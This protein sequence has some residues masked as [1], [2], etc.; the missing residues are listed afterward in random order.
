MRVGFR[1]WVV[2][3][4]FSGMNPLQAGTDVNV[5]EPLRPWV[6][7]VLHAEQQ[8]G[9]PFV[10]HD[11]KQKFCHWP[12]RLALTVQNKSAEFSSLWH[13]STAG[14]VALPGDKKHWPHKVSV[15]QKAVPVLLKNNQ[16]V[17]YL[18]AGK[19]HIEGQ[20]MW[21]RIPENLAIPQ[22]T[23]VFDLQ[24]Q[25]RQVPFPMIKQGRVWLRKTSQSQKPEAR[26]ENSMDVQVFR[27]V[28][29]DV[30][31]QVV[32]V[33]QLQVSGQQREIMLP[34]ALLQGF[35]AVSINSP[36]PA[37]LDSEGRLLLKIKPGRWLVELK[38]RHP[39]MLNQLTLAI[40]NA[41]WP[42][43]EIWSF[44][45]MPYQR[46]VEV[47]NVA[48]LDPSQTNLPKAWHNLP[49]YQM[50]Q[51]G[52]MKF[53]LIRRGDP[54]PEPNQL[55]LS[56]KLWLDFDGAGY[57]VEDRI[58]GKMTAGWRLNALPQTRVGQVQLNGRSQLITRLP[59]MQP[60][61]VEVRKGQIQLKADSRLEGVATE[62][63][64]VGWQQ[65]FQKVSA[66]LNLPPGWR[67][68]ATAG[69]DNVPNSWI[70]RW[71][72]LD[73]FMVLIAALA[74]ARLWSIG[75]GVFALCF[76]ALIWHE[77]EAPRYIWLNLLA[78]I[79]L[80]RV[81][82]EGRFSQWIRGYRNLCWGVMVLIILPFMVTQVRLALYPQLQHWR[83]ISHEQEVADMGAE[84][85]QMMDEAASVMPQSR[86]MS[87]NKTSSYSQVKKRDIYKRIDPDANIQTGPGLPQWQWHT[88]RLSWNGQVD[89]SQQLKLW[90]LSPPVNM[91]LNILRAALVVVFAF[92]MLGMWKKT[93]KLQMPTWC[94]LIVPMLGMLP[95]TPIQAAF[96]D[97]K[98]LK[99]LKSRLLQA[100]DCL[101]A[102]AQ[103]A[104]M[105]I[106]IE[107]NRMHIELL[108][109]AHQTT[110]IPLPAQDGQWFPQRVKI[111]GEQ[112][113][114]LIRHQSKLWLL[115]PAGQQQVSLSGVFHAA[116]QFTLPLPLLPHRV[117]L[118]QQGWQVSGLHE[119]GRSA[120][121]L[122]FTRKQRQARA[123][124]EESFQPSVLPP[125]VR[126]ERTLALDLDWT[127][128]TRITR[129]GSGKAPIVFAFPLMA[130]ESV[131]SSHVR[132]KERQVLVN[133]PV[134][135]NALQWQSALKKSEEIVLQASAQG[136][137]MDVWRADVSPVWHLQTEGIAVVHHQDNRGRWL[138]EWRPW[139]GEQVRLQMSRPQA[140]AGATLTMD[141]STVKITQGKRSQDGE[142]SF[143]MRSSKGG[144][145]SVQLPS[146]AQL[147]SVVIN[148]VTQPIRQQGN[149]VTLPVKPGEQHVQL[150]WHE[151]L[152]H[153][154]WLTTPE[155]NL[156]YAS[157]NSHTHVILGKDRW[158][159][160]AF[161]PKFG[162]AVLFWSVLIV[163]C[164]VAVGLAKI[165]LT[166]LGFGSWFLLLIGLS[167]IPLIAAAV[168]VAWLMLL[169]MRQKY[170][171]QTSAHF[172]LLQVI[173]ALFSLVSLLLLFFAIQQGLLGSP[174]MQISGNQSGAFNLQW[175]QDR[176]AEILPTATVVSVPLMVYRVLMLLWSLW[177]AMSL[178]N[179]L[180]WGW[181]CFSEGGL[182]HKT[183]KKKDES[184]SEG[185]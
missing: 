48:S 46:V 119:D 166:P 14:W 52:V 88:V 2:L 150:L 120:S 130:G 17:V 96:P 1:L 161:G 77:A 47:H 71:T 98:M 73:L 95:T 179:W 76:L 87:L 7:W 125:F 173:L 180:K 117:T 82:P 68:L 134:G 57:T 174:D 172:N 153:A 74:T 102:C 59:G 86:V 13:L 135:Q 8:H 151:S 133:M 109:D 178:L 154:F 113:S 142:L 124:E 106:R 170:H 67:L 132:V 72:L 162:P 85:P 123:H 90:L 183:E 61:G 140:V 112:A 139:P 103:I 40:D 6:D 116:H 182:W 167:Q 143:R 19:Q 165:K 131:T 70:S 128:H 54:E 185:K 32:S 30:P 108:A 156:G 141:K 24:V 58:N 63:S 37:R 148:S 171:W 36:L 41:D 55:Q 26:V 152:P 4:L 22:Q 65:A 115:L 31:L 97:D 56:R 29:D 169:G 129:L 177:L 62:I 15:N 175:Y 89:Q 93:G 111:N 23:G 60:Y 114:A 33:F 94:W 127:I 3:Y 145:H 163:L 78:A 44:Q 168:V 81:L 181:R 137:W 21:N 155:I 12:G 5:P 20:F 92:L 80:L 35:V 51:G 146:Q 9:C 27:K 45:S 66:E 144:Q 69:V 42:R 53:K 158:V 100:P 159:L 39:T 83:S 118:S 157:V 136:Q 176:A 79:A 105:A 84:A 121:Q 110:A 101:P 147:K 38:A 164:A 75:W 18:G 16:P 122:Q 184:V 43:S 149:Q 49:A 11:F 50:P 91:A 107:G 126:V 10:Y 99:E 28:I 64:A 25:G 34:H 104:K 138:P 160:F